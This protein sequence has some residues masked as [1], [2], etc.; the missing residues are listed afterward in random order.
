MPT[1][2]E[3]V[4]RIYIKL[5]GNEVQRPVMQKLV[6]VVV[7][8]HTHLPDFFTIRFLDE[9]LELL[10]NGPFD[11]I[12]E[13]EIEAAKQDGNK[14]SLIKGEITALEP[15]YNEGMIAELL[16][17]GYDKSHRLFREHKS[18]AFLNKKD[19]DLAEEIANAA[20]LQAEIERTTAIYD[21]IYQRNQTDLNFLM[22]RAWRIGYECFVSDGK[23]YFR[24]PP[25]GD[26]SLTL[27]W[28]TDLLSFHPRMTLAEQIDEVVV[29]GWDVDKKEPIV[30]RAN[31]GHLYPG[32][33][34]SKDGKTW[35]QSFGSGKKVIVDQPVR[36][37]VEADTFATARMDEVSGA[38]VEAQGVAFRRPDIKAGAIANI[39]NL[40]ERF[41]G[42]YL[43]THATH[44][45]TADGLTTTFNVRGSR[46]GLLSEQ[47]HRQP[48]TDHWQGFVIAIVTNT[49]DPQNW[50]RVRVKY[51]WLTNDAESNWARVIGIGAGPE[52]GYCVIPEVGDEVLVGFIHGD[53]S[54]PCVL[55][56]LWNGQDKLPPETDGA[57]GGE[58]PKVRSWRSRTGHK[59]A[60]Y[61]N[62]DNKIEIVTSGGHEITLDDTNR[63][64]N[65]STSGGLKMTLDDGGRKITIHS[66]N[67]IE[68]KSTG[69]LK[70]QAGANLDLQASAQI[71]IK[72]AMVNIN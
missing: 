30:G 54:Q 7:D 2:R 13:V 24:K 63:K 45:L 48:L 67:E 42:S 8:Q 49:D 47:L 16:V 53:F 57:S 66:G 43:I 22:Q 51:P 14:V 18:K 32:I 10:D 60:I 71:N 29:K 28:G 69:N 12:K 33:Q 20:G 46:L 21:H 39:Q 17:R 6:E 1:P 40:G 70:I 41:S 44:V 27:T 25:S 56:G 72:G 68:V 9:N 31:H 26:A 11:L 50:G 55:G 52:T 58:K 64:I 5:D 19:S 23:L 35:A 36:S 62:T 3:L 61:D 37:Q 15:L 4:S 59:I 34:E 38:F 65:L